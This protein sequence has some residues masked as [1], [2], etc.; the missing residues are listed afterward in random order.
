MVLPISTEQI[1]TAAELRWELRL[2][3]SKPEDAVLD[4]IVRRAVAWI[5]ENTRLP[6]MPVYETYEF[7]T[8][9]AETGV[10]HDRKSII[11][12]ISNVVKLA[13]LVIDG[14]EE[15]TGDI[16][17]AFIGS[18]LLRISRKDKGVLIREVA[19]SIL[20]SVWR[21]FH[22]ESM[23]MENVKSLI[24]A[25]G[26]DIFDGL[27]FRQQIRM[28]LPMISIV[29]R[30]A[31][32]QAPIVGVQKL[33]VIGGKQPSLPYDLS[34]LG[35]IDE[36]PSGTILKID[37]KGG[38][39]VSNPSA[40][41][42]VLATITPPIASALRDK[43]TNSAQ[44]AIDQAWYKAPGSSAFDPF[45]SVE[46]LSRDEGDYPAIVS[47]K[48]L[49]VWPQYVYGMAFELAQ[50]GRILDRKSVL[51]P[52][53][54]NTEIILFNDYRTSASGKV[55]L[56]IERDQPT[57]EYRV[58]V[59]GF[60]SDTIANSEHPSIS[61]NFF[62]A[63]DFLSGT[64]NST[65]NAKGRGS[66]VLPTIA[67][68]ADAPS[69][70][71]WAISIWSPFDRMPTAIEEI[72]FRLQGRNYREAYGSSVLNYPLL[73]DGVMGRVYVFAASVSISAYSSTYQGV[74]YWLWH[75]DDLAIGNF[76]VFIEAIEGEFA[77]GAYP[78]L[79]LRPMGMF[80]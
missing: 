62:M 23:D 51:W 53:D 41:G 48:L 68:A 25:I 57:F 36:H 28:T 22:L 5:I 61:T 77:G 73:V 27:A 71:R 9:T 15:D 39:I 76:D 38:I 43:R 74:P 79:R 35:P 65:Y 11:V 10:S 78:E 37:S 40:Y 32:R 4:G 70:W 7:T 19:G 54:S 8:P 67:E 50:A 42:P 80:F 47:P 66:A 21:G 30:M 58:A 13:A 17:G 18:G 46:P 34:R 75:G 63:D 6:V 59:K 72:V 29:D 1:M 52:L 56:S 24:A 44:P 2:Q 26:R 55:F 33:E 49:P 31:A 14:E 20:I 12:G 45:I 69:G 3:P 64:A 16:E 60:D